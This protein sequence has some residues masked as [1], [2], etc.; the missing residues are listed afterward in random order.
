MSPTIIPHVRA[1][2]E[3]PT[4]H[5][6]AGAVGRTDAEHGH[7]GSGDEKIDLLAHH[8]DDERAPQRA[9]AGAIVQGRHGGGRVCDIVVVGSA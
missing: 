9:P 2:V 7:Y 6:G 1:S 4:V 5:L 8:V 3:K